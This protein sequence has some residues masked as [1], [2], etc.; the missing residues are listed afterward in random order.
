M[1][2]GDP[3]LAEAPVETPWA[4]TAGIVRSAGTNTFS[5]A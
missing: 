5:I 1:L 4:S 3:D 2:H